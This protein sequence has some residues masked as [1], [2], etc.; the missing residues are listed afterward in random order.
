MM[1]EEQLPG[2]IVERISIPYLQKFLDFLNTSKDIRQRLDKGWH[3]M[4]SSERNDTIVSMWANHRNALITAKALASNLSRPL[5]ENLAAGKE[6]L[7]Q[8]YRKQEEALRKSLAEDPVRLRDELGN[9][10]IAFQFEQFDE[11][12]KLL[13]Q[14]MQP[15]MLLTPQGIGFDLLDTE[16]SDIVQNSVRYRQGLIYEELPAREVKKPARRR[17]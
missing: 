1:G 13:E 12:T 15:V 17:D 16:I 10:E 6:I 3:D 2:G 7:S 5:E 11:Q 9:L 4:Y 8:K 14:V